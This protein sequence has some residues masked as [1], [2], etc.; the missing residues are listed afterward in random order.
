MNENRAE[1]AAKVVLG[2]F[3]SAVGE[4]VDDPKLRLKGAGR[5][6]G[7]RVQEAAGAAQETLGVLTDSARLAASTVGDAYGKVSDI[8]AEIDPFVRDKPYLAV[9]I[10]AAAGL[11][12]GLLIAGRG[13]RVIYVKPRV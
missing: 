8:A 5:Q 11:L 12:A 10:A 2:K 3:E 13:P 7:G 4:A 9:A 1:G 6:A